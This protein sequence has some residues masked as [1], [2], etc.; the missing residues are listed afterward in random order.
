MVV[1]V[2]FVKQFKALLVQTSA[3]INQIKKKNMLCFTIPVKTKAKK[4]NKSFVSRTHRRA[5]KHTVAS[6]MDRA[7]RVS[8]TFRGLNNVKDRIVER[9]V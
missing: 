7:Q 6:W 8:E 2:V 3:C 9:D 4:Q 5:H 1:A